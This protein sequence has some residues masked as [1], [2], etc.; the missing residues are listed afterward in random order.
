[1]A[2]HYNASAPP[3]AE[4]PV[5]EDLARL[6]WQDA[7]RRLEKRLDDLR[8]TAERVR[9]H[10][11]DQQDEL[12]GW[13]RAAFELITGADDAPLAFASLGRR[14]Q[15]GFLTW[16]EVYRNP[17][18]IDGAVALIGEALSRRGEHRQ[19]T[20]ALLREQREAPLD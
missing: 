17:S 11:R 9:E 12:P 13:L 8:E 1:M 14:V 16:D 2:E 7:E 20:L 5:S 10:D 18:P 15:E 4:P 3:K 6:V 19:H